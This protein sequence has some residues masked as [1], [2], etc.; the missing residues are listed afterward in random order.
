MSINDITGDKIATK[1]V[2]DTYR[3]NFGS[4]D[5]SKKTGSIAIAS[6]SPEH[7]CRHS[8]AATM[9]LP[10]GPTKCIHCGVLMKDVPAEQLLTR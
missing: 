3:N 10:P 8:W 5:W 7:V 9:V 1:Q 6:T 2:T 4:I